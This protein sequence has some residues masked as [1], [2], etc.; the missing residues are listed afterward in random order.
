ME[1][2]LDIRSRKSIRLLHLVDGELSTVNNHVVQPPLLQLLAP[3]VLL[4]AM[5]AQ[6]P[7]HM[8]VTFLPNAVRTVH[9]LSIHSGV[10][11]RIV[12]Y[13]GISAG[14]I[15]T[16][17]FQTNTTIESSKIMKK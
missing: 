10:P 16:Y 4:Y 2:G 9:R 12:K 5:L 15:Q 14:Q 8:H 17:I 3:N 6:K 11:I 13:Y 1:H 7:V